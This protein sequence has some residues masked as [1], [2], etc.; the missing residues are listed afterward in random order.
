MNVV[1]VIKQEGKPVRLVHKGGTVILGGVRD[2]SE[3]PMKL[4]L[5]TYYQLKKQ[6]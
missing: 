5:A 6:A 2:A 1:K 4:N 3:L